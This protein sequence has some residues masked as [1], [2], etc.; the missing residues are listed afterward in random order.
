MI[1]E[2]WEKKIF[3]LIYNLWLNYIIDRCRKQWKVQDGMH[4]TR[5]VHL[6]VVIRRDIFVR[7]VDFSPIMCVLN[8][9]HDIAP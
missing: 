6:Q 5:H 1:D 2:R 8:V 4:I 3:F 9:V 7:L